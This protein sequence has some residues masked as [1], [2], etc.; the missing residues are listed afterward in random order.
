M[1][2]DTTVGPSLYYYILMILLIRKLVNLPT[3]EVQT[4]I[5]LLSK[6]RIAASFQRRNY[7]FL[8]LV[9]CILQISTE[10]GA[11]K[12]PVTALMNLILPPEP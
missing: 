9:H 5:M 12:F 8:I 1:Y 10:D 4:D 7:N 2:G 3:I 11:Q 6:L